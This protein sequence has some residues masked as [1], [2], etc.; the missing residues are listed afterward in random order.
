MAIYINLGNFADR[1]VNIA[2]ACVAGAS[3]VFNSVL[4]V[5]TSR[6]NNRK[7]VALLFGNGKTPE[8]SSVLFSVTANNCRFNSG[9]ESCNFDSD[10]DDF[11]NFAGGTAQ[12]LLDYLIERF[13]DFTAAKKAFKVTFGNVGHFLNADGEIIKSILSIEKIEKID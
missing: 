6:Y 2:N 9:K 1:P 5:D 11:I 7:K 3:V 10:P 12:E 4:A 13:G 8:T